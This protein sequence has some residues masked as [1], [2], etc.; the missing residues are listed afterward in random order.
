[1]LK[2]TIMASSGAA[3]DVVECPIGATT[4]RLEQERFEIP[5]GAALGFLAQYS[6]REFLIYS[7]REFLIITD[8]AR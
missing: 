8:S 4:A 7:A 3:N 6:A 5:Y 2:L 1:V